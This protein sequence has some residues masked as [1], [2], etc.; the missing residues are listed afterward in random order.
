MNVQVGNL[1]GYENISHRNEKASAFVSLWERV[2]STPRS[3]GRGVGEPALESELNGAAIRSEL[4]P[5][6]LLNLVGIQI[7]GTIFT[8]CGITKRPSGW[9]IKF[10]S[11]KK[12]P[13]LT[14]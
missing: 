4:M 7:K 10:L 5:C 13:T 8:Y 2:T 12:L 11:W 6:P 14:K 3:E 9:T 1:M